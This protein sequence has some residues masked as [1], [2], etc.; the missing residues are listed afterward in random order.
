MQCVQHYVTASNI[1]L[2]LRHCE[3][4]SGFRCLD[5]RIT[6][7]PVDMAA[8]FDLSLRLVLSLLSH[9]DRGFCANEPPHDDAAHT[10]RRSLTQ[11]LPA[12]GFVDR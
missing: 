3:P 6:F 4:C 9:H 10:I 11:C 5:R 8:A 2:G 7:F 1:A 12:L